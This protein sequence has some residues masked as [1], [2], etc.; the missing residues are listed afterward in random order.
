MAGCKTDFLCT[1]SSLSKILFLYTINLVNITAIASP[2]PACGERKR[3]ASSV[4]LRFV[5]FVSKV[6][7]LFMCKNCTVIGSGD[8]ACKESSVRWP[9]ASGFCY[10][11]SEFCY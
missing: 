1:L 11:A 4:L 6:V 5:L 10:Q 7:M 2:K 9:R 3:G 8:T